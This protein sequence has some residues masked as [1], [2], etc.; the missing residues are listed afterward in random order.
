MFDYIKEQVGLF[1]KSRVFVL[2]IVTVLL[3][4][5]LVQKLYSLQIVEGQQFAEEAIMQIRKERELTATRGNILDRNGNVLAYNELAYSVTIE[6]NGSYEDTAEKNEQLNATIYQL[7][8]MIEQNGDSIDD[9]DFGIILDDQGEFQ[10][11]T[12]AG[13]TSRYRFLADIYGLK[14]TSDLE[15]EQK[16]ATADEVMDYFCNGPKDEKNNSMFGIDQK[17]YDKDAQLGITIVRYNL[18]L[19]RFSKY[20][21]VKVATDINDDTRALIMENMADLQGVSVEEDSV[22]RY[23]YSEYMASI[24]GYTGLISQEEYDD[25]ESAGEEDYSLT[26]VVGKAGLEK[27]M[28]TYL[29]GTK[30]SEVIYVDNVG[31]VLDTEDRVDPVAGNDVYLSIDADLQKAA[32]HVV[33]Q[34]IAGILLDKIIPGNY[35][36]TGKSKDIKI[37]INDVWFAFFDNEVLDIAHFAEDDAGETETKVQQQFESKKESV[38][39]TLREEL[40]SDNPA[41]YKDS[42]EEYQVYYSY[43][44]NTYLLRTTGILMSDKIDEEDEMYVRWKKDEDISLQEFLTYA[45]S[46]NWVDSS[47]LDIDS[48]YSSASEVYNALTDYL[49]ENLTDEVK[50]NKKMYKYMIESGTVSGTD[51]CL[52]LFEQ[53]VLEE[54]ETDISKLKNGYSA[55][56]FIKNKIKNLE[57]TP[58]QLALEPCTGSAV[59]T[60]VNSGEVLACVSYPG[61][62][63][64]QLANTMDT[65]YYNYLYDNASQPFYNH[66]TQETTAP[67]STFKMVSAIAGLEE[68]VIGTETTVTDKGIYE[69]GNTGTTHRCHIYVS[70]RG[71]HGTINVT[72]ALKLSC[73]YFFYDVGFQLSTTNGSNYVPDRG[74]EKL[75]KYANLVGLG[76][77]TGIE[78]TESAGQVSDETPVPSA[79]GQGT[80]AYTTAQLARY[81]ATV[82][83]NGVRYDLTLLQRAEDTEG[84]VVETF[85]NDVSDEATSV[86]STSWQAAQK[87]MKMVVDNTQI[88]QEM[89]VTMAGKTGTAEQSSNHANHALFVGYAP[90]EDPEIAFSMRITNGYT[91]ANAAEMARDIVSY[92]FGEKTMEDIVTGTADEGSG[93]TIAD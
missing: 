68:G 64:N 75:A 24:I 1:V 44:V 74:I 81:V 42:S 9:S 84:N 61:Y 32:Y 19:N 41:S 69:V 6:D 18:W 80:N 26:D 14:S 28:D 91:S 21:S 60:D 49:V 27:E 8:T 35:N 46:M 88:F 4:A 55:Y 12:D 83:N 2:M 63:N 53:G 45:I 36:H 58:S 51:V 87:G 70:S 85:T 22:R 50:F 71:S 52:L 90:Y 17:L 11:T 73:N 25:Y 76:E 59:V 82:A 15:D 39:E 7:I 33:E 37:P 92:Y 78:I 3:F 20:V 66:A 31:K 34:K 29:Q 38:T 67:G 62:D 30:G 72:E 77:Y 40:T 65:D 48:K 13:T 56:S 16:N 10:F 43:I 79:I 47:K 86:S 23:N 89:N 54:N 57:I 93:V 5:V